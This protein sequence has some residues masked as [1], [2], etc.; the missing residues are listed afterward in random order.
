MLTCTLLLTRP[1]NGMAQ[2]PQ[3]PSPMVE[4]T[5]QHPR[6]TQTTPP[7]LRQ[8]LSLGTLFVPEK[9]KGKRHVKL[10]LFFHGGDWLPELAVSRQHN[11]AVITVQAGAGSSTYEKLFADP[12]TFP[13][14]LAEAESAAGVPF[15]EIDLG[16]WSAGCGALRQLLSDPASYNRISRVLCIDGVHAGYV[17][18]A[19]NTAPA[20]AEPEL[21]PA[22]LRSWL[23]FGTDAIAG[24][25]RLIITHSEI[26]PATYASTTE[27]ADALL[28]QWGLTPQP[29]VR[30]GPMGTQMLS[31]TKSGGLLV[32]GFA[33]NSA[34]DHVDQMQS[35]P[36]YLRW[37]SKSSR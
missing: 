36:E 27:T 19:N 17:N 14:L 15:S 34:P 18:S 2:Q 7:G 16:G 8:K 23:H 32:V 6:L 21:E 5:R 29:V 24:K 13:K 12:A 3:N 31:E 33:G 1:A 37:L 11:M 26:F 9:L 35:L 20:A 28:H 4:H 25:K 30:W 22:N 10:L